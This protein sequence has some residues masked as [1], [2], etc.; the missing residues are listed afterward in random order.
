MTTVVSPVQLLD[1]L[2]TAHEQS[3]L[4]HNFS[5]DALILA[6]LGSGSYV[7]AIT[8]AIMTIGGTHAPLLD[9]Y[10]VLSVPAEDVSTSV[11]A[12]VK[13]GVKVPGW[14]NGFIKDVADPIWGEVDALLRESDAALMKKVDLITEALHAA[15]KRIYPNPSCYTAAAALVLGMPRDAI[16]FLFISGRLPAWTKEFCRVLAEGHA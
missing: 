4:R 8:A 2:N 10:R 14:G 12:F 6:S 15:G 13:A 16:P 7:Q 9:T 1:A 11:Q 5:H 3:A